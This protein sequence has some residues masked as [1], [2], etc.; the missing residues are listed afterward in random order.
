MVGTAVALPPY[1]INHK[2]HGLYISGTFTSMSAVTVKLH[3]GGG[4]TG[5]NS[6]TFHKYVVG[7]HEIETVTSTVYGF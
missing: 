7:S 3:K 5:L 1:I 6:L 4:A 2:A